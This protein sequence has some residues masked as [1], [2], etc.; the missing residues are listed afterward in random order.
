MSYVERLQS[1]RHQ[2]IAEVFAKLYDGK[3]ANIGS[4]E[5]IVDEAVIAT[6][7]GLPRMGQSWFK[8]TTTK[9]LNFKVYLKA[10]FRDIT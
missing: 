3:R 4:L 10:E 1:G 6:A 9:N 2:T 7:T 5:M 8:T